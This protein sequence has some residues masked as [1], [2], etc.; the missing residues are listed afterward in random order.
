M[1]AIYA[2][3]YYLD[4]MLFFGPHISES[5]FQILYPNTFDCLLCILT[6]VAS[7]SL[8]TRYSARPARPAAHH[9][10]AA[11][12]ARGDGADRQDP[13]HH[14]GATGEH[15]E[16]AFLVTFVPYCL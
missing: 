5:A 11:L 9:P 1:L 7:C 8:P 13:G 4:F 6:P 2:F 14:G 15:S 12:H 3:S 10:D 16:S